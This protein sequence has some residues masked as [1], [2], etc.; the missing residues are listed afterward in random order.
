[1]MAYGGE[2]IEQKVTKATKA[3]K[4]QSAFSGVDLLN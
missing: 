3:C 1:M 4:W 2:K